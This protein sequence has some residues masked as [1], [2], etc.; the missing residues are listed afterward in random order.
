M[1]LFR[2]IFNWIK[3][4]FRGD[5]SIIQYDIIDSTNEQAKRLIA[6]GAVR[7]SAVI[8]ADQQSAGRTTK[9]NHEWK[10]PTGNAYV[11]YVYKTDAK[12]LKNLTE[13]ST[14]TSAAILKTI[15]YFAMSSDIK[16][17]NA[18]IKWPNDVL[19]NEK[20]L[21][22]VLIETEKVAGENFVII[23]AGI[24]VLN[25][26]E[27]SSGRMATCLKDEGIYVQPQRFARVYARFLRK[28][29]QK[30]TDGKFEG[31]RDF[32][33]SQSYRIGEQITIITKDGH[34][35]SGRFAHVDKHGVMILETK[36]GEMER[37][38]SGKIID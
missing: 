13:I 12:A 18:K 31:I 27:L 1:K 5:F 6:T 25:A 21:S 20:K 14:V 28:L 17:I 4:W 24:N 9:F 16:S 30:L 23:G 37:I 32:V 36:T 35:I 15:Q 22:G 10:S 11:S 2:K 29:L 38:V 7:D 34:K 26:P 8:V 33:L 3:S 19:I